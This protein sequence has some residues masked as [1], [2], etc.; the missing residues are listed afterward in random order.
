MSWTRP[1]CSCCRRVTIC[2]YRVTIF[3]SGKAK[4]SQ[5]MSGKGPP[6]LQLL[7]SRHNLLVHLLISTVRVSPSQLLP[8]RYDFY[9]WKSE[10]RSRY[11]MKKVYLSCSC[12][13]CITFCS[14]IYSFQWYLCL[15]ASCCLR[16]TIFTIGK[17]ENWSVYEL[18]KAQLQLLP[19]RYDFYKRKSENRWPAWPA[20][21]IAAL[22]LRF[23]R[24]KKRKQV[25]ATGLTS[26]WHSCLRVTMFMSGKAKTG[27]DMTWKR[28]TSAA[29]VV[30]ASQSAST[31]AFLYGTL[32]SKPAATIFAPSR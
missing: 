25:F 7:P 9:K 5:N 32:G 29:V 24:P 12:C 11:E 18:E 10:N 28:F 30:V 2:W 22:A 4:T 15:L 31:S 3:R 14:Y 21:G 16:V 17:G 20:A 19:S 23:L 1:T 8:P 13:R 27:L 26:C 6:Q